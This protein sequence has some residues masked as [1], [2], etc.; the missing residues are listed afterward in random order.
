MQKLERVIIYIYILTNYHC[1]SKITKLLETTVSEPE[2]EKI[3]T[4]F[5]LYCFLDAIP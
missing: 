4:K 1:N 3:E 5:T 2:M